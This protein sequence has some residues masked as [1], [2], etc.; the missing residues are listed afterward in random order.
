MVRV[1]RIHQLGL[2]FLDIGLFLDGTSTNIKGPIDRSN[3]SNTSTILSSNNDLLFLFI[4][5]YFSSLNDS[6]TQ[7][8]SS[9]QLE[10]TIAAARPDEVSSER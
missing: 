1:G 5:L 6:K 10:Q 4:L 8:W 3:L 7:E 9:G 2:C